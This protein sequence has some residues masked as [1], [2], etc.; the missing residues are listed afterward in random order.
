MRRSAL[1]PRHVAVRPVPI[2]RATVKLKRAL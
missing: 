1:K 2:G